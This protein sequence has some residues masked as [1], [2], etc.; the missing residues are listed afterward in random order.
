MSEQTNQALTHAI[1]KAFGVL[2]GIGDIFRNMD[3]VLALILLKYLSD[4]SDGHIKLDDGQTGTSLLQFPPCARFNFL[5]NKCEIPGNGQRIDSA[6]RA[7]ADTIPSFKGVFEIIQFDSGLLGDELRRDQTLAMLLKIFSQVHFA[8]SADHAD[9]LDSFFKSIAIFR[10]R[11]GGEF[12]TPPEIAELL[13]MLMAPQLGEEICDPACGT[14]SLLIQCA[15]QLQPNERSFVSLY[16]QEKNTS[17][18]ALA[19]MNLVL[20][21]ESNTHIE[22][23]DTL[24][25]PCF[26]DH[27]SNLKQF[28][29]VISNP[30]FNV[31]DW[32]FEIA[33][34]DPFRRFERGVPPRSRADFAFILHMVGC[35]K[36]LTGRMAVMV[37]HGVLF[38]QGGEEKIRQS[39][40]ADNLIDAVI[41]LPPKLLFN[42]SIP[43]VILVLRRRKIDDP[44]LFVDASQSFK[45]GTI[46]NSLRSE[47]IQQIVETCKER[48]S[49]EG[50]AYLA[51]RAEIKAKGCNL[52]IPLYFEQKVVP[53]SVDLE[54]VRAELRELNA[55]RHSLEKEVASFRLQTINA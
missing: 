33:K 38:R 12:Y 6:L 25:A 24:R 41:G 27:E 52:N 54:A 5:L 20:H 49:A 1:G 22:Q 23:G 19:K 35:M 40:I 29:I 45:L 10:V 32:G 14:G 47:D 9:E 18:W 51:S 42:S 46:Y 11:G 31:P 50:Y 34:R 37:P 3:H 39:L 44:V 17:T 30:P 16:G 8:A 26:A 15:Q 13:A 2:R 43:T 36:P 55:E 28:D 53:K 4:Q 7:I 21:G 48:K